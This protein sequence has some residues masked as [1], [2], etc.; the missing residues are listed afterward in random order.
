MTLE[1]MLKETM[2]DAY[3]DDMSKDDLQAF[4]K[5]QILSSGEYTNSNKANAEKKEL[6]D[7]L[8]NL[9]AELDAK[10]T[11]DDKKKKADADTKKL[12][13]KLQKELSESKAN[14]SKMSAIAFLSDA[15]S[16]AGI[17][18]EDAEFDEFVTSISFEDKDK[19]DKVSKYVSKIVKAAYEAGKSEADKKELGKMGAFKDGQNSGSDEKG[20]FGKELAQTMKV[21]TTGQVDFFERSK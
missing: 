15:K 10:M 19:T 17:Q 20:A 9:Q 7:K 5:K 21:D 18:D 16:H 12:I 4:F 1:E 6:S 3:K 8:A 2:G 13:E 11:D 14:Q